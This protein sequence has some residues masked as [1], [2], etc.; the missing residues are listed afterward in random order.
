[1]QKMLFM[2]VHHVPFDVFERERNRQVF[3]SFPLLYLAVVGLRS[4]QRSQLL[5]GR[6]S[7]TGPVEAELGS[8]VGHG[9]GVRSGTRERGR[10]RW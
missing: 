1:M 5:A 2:I 6:R 8:V 10:S 4:R 9:H 3:G 7:S